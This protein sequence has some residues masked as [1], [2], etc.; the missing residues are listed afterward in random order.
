MYDIIWILQ[1]IVVLKRRKYIVEEINLITKEWL[2]QLDERNLRLESPGALQDFISK[3][4]AIISCYVKS[5][6]SSH[7]CEEIVS[8]IKF[9]FGLSDENLLWILSDTKITYRDN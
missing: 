2:K 6:M 7:I 9:K 8:K 4:E 3:D 5:D 1:K